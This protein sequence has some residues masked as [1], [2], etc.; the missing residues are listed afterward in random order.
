MVAWSGYFGCA[1]RTSDLGISTVR[2]AGGY[3]GMPDR[4]YFP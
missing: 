3:I 4:S 1:G 2:A